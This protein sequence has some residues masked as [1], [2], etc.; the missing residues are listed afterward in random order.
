MDMAHD[1]VTVIYG[2]PIIWWQKRGAQN[3]PNLVYFGYDSLCELW[4]ALIE[5][6][7]P[8][9]FKQHHG[10]TSPEMLKRFKASV[11][12]NHNK[13]LF[14]C[15]SEAV[16]KLPSYLSFIFC[17]FHVND[18]DITVLKRLACECV[19]SIKTM[20]AKQ[21]PWRV[22]NTLAISKLRF[23]NTNLKIFSYGVWHT[24]RQ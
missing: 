10:G 23:S 21:V 6:D 13:N 11:S 15:I 17:W 9:L 8:V 19:R 12:Y 1:V 7:G 4:I 22:W 14:D 2:A 16:W 5:R 24:N 18:N 20:A 3:G